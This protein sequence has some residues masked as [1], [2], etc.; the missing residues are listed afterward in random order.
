MKKWAALTLALAFPLLFAGSGTLSQPVSQSAAAAN[1]SGTIVGPALYVSDVTRS[2]K[3]YGDGLGMQ[4][5]MQFGPPGRQDIVL[6]FGPDPSQ[7]SIML[8]SDKTAT[9]RKVE[10][11]HGFDR[12]ALLMTDLPA[13][14]ARLRTLGFAPSEIREVHGTHL[15]MMVSD[16][17]GYRFELLAPKP[18]K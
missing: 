18:A 7:P 14:A 17:D 9:P 8:L 15:M 16:R 3:F 1:P 6:G 10:Q 12:I 13:V 2:L 5:R 4:V 11:T